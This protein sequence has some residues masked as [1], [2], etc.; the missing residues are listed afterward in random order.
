MMLLISNYEWTGIEIKVAR[1]GAFVLSLFMQ[2]LKD[3]CA[4]KVLWQEASKERKDGDVDD[5][6][7][8]SNGYKVSL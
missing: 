1:R 8:Q 3:S 4:L 7:D 5:S 2:L 6:I